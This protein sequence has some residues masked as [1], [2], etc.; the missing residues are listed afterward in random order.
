MTDINSCLPYVGA[1]IEREKNGDVELLI[2]TRWKPGIDILY[3][4]TF[5]FPAGVMDRPYENVYNI[6]EREI[7]E[8]TGLKLKCVKND[9]KTKEYS[10]QMEDA[11]FGFRPFFCTQQLKKGLPWIG[12]VFLCGVEDGI[13]KAQKEEVKNVR[14]MK[15]EEVRELFTNSP[16]KFFTLEVPAWD[17]YF[18]QFK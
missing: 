15:R 11:A 10:S 3:S 9:Y 8:E 12:F 7:K 2:Q 6:L 18:Q 16:E 14:W 17:Y 1:I 13:P 5:E 4:G